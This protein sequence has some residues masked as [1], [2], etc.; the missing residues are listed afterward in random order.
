MW[1]WRLT[2]GVQKSVSTK[3]YQFASLPIFTTSKS[4]VFLCSLHSFSIAKHKLFGS[5]VYLQRPYP[6][7]IIVLPS[8]KATKSSA[9]TERRCGIMAERRMVS[10]SIVGSDD[11]LSLGFEARALY[12]HLIAEADDDGFV[13]NP[14]KQMRIVGTG[15]CALTELTSAGFIHAFTSSVCV[16]LHW[17]I[18]NRVRQDR[19]KPTRF[20]EERAMLKM[21]KDGVYV[22]REPSL[23][24]EAAYE[25]SESRE[26]VD[27]STQNSAENKNDILQ[28]NFH[29]NENN[30]ENFEGENAGLTEN[31]S[32]K[33]SKIPPKVQN[34]NTDLE[35][36]N[37]P[38]NTPKK[39]NDI[40]Q[41]NF[42]KNENNSENFEGENAGLTENPSE[43]LSKIPQK[44]QNLNIKNRPENKNDILQ[45]NFCE[46][47]NKSEDF[48]GENAGFAENQAENL[49]NKE[50]ILQFLNALPSDEVLIDKKIKRHKKKLSKSLPFP[51]V[52]EY[53][54]R[55]DIDYIE[56]LTFDDQRRYGERLRELENYFSRMGF[57]SSWTNF[58]RFNEARLW[59]GVG[60]ENVMDRLFHYADIWEQKERVRRGIPIKNGDFL[61]SD[62][63][64]EYDD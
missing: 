35:I 8:G 32:E 21:T 1:N 44:V 48:E 20:T 30:S 57:V 43:K 18:H 41:E 42:H 7:V 9:K 24:P 55:W 60:G 3:F 47:E 22:V 33:L 17:C 38:E 63:K 50:A 4:A 59:R 23:E 29:K 19:Y 2:G 25:S 58:V 37:R 36:K 39:Q 15:E 45:E 10:K 40:L 27:L 28:E 31:P 12:L 46:N 6:C 62:E 61:E 51:M 26:A 56:L 34:L 5:G 11:F 64:M 14:K 13:A 54:P 53:D 16:V 52:K 49:S